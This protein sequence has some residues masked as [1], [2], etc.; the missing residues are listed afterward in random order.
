MNIWTDQ[1]EKKKD[2]GRLGGE[3]F[4]MDRSTI[5]LMGAVQSRNMRL[6]KILRN[7]RSLGM[8]EDGTDKVSR[9]KRPS[10]APFKALIPDT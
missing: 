6:K 3:V 10:I 4:W 7:E 5:R 2:G 8:I 1:I 9:L